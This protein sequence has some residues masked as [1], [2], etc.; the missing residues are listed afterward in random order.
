V[1]PGAVT[2]MAVL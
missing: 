1:A 2:E